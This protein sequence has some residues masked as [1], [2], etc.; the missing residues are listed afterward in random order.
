MAGA[1]VALRAVGKGLVAVLAAVVIPVPVMAAFLPTPTLL[2]EVVVAAVAAADDDND[3]DAA[4]AAAGRCGVGR[5]LT[6][7][8]PPPPPVGGTVMVRELV[9]ALLFPVVNVDVPWIG[10]GVDPAVDPGLADGV[11]RDGNGNGDGDGPVLV[12]VLLLL[13]LVLWLLWLLLLLLATLAT[14]AVLIEG[15]PPPP[16]PT[17]RGGGGG[18]VGPLRRIA[19]ADAA[20]LGGELNSL[21]KKLSSL[22]FL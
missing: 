21:L 6:V 14:A 5:D 1:R 3:D 11:G 17:M 13:L 20:G 12:L 16:P 19:S 18:G 4:A 22:I 7:A 15:S 2:L 8:L 10:P 9:G